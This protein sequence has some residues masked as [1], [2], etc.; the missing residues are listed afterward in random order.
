MRASINWLTYFVSLWVLAVI[1]PPRVA[2]AD[3]AL[4]VA[5]FKTANDQPELKQAAAAGDPGLHSELGEI[6]GLQVAA[7]PALDLPGLQLAM[8]CVGET[9]ACLAAAATQTQVDG[10]VAPSLTR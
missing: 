1:T 10:L 6:A 7:L 3:G 4:R 5:L 8:D 2:R 9:P